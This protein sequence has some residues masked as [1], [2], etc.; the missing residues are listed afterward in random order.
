M[1]TRGPVPYRTEE[2]SRERNANRGDDRPVLKKGTMREVQIP[3]PDPQ[4]HPT[5]LRLYQALRESG[6]CD[7]FQNSDWAFAWSVCEDI[8]HM[9]FDRMKG[10]S[11][12]MLLTALYN[13]LGNLMFTEADR[14]RLRI[15]LME[16]QDD[17]ESY[18]EKK[19]DEYKNVLNFKPKEE[20][21]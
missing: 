9:K 5:A 15:E 3:E 1:G 11:N 2:L 17:E 4:W 21:G 12:A 6:Q 16:E 19:V 20:T 8:S 7:F 10:K 14:R 18:G 13:A